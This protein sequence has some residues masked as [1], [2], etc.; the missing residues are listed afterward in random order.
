[1]AS[2]YVLNGNSLLGAVASALSSDELEPQQRVAETLLGLLGTQ[3][4]DANKATAQDA[5]ALQVRYQVEVGFEA[6]HLSSWTQGSR[7]ESYRGFVPDLHPL[8]ARLVSSL[9]SSQRV[10]VF[11]TGLW[12][13]V[14]SR[15]PG[16]SA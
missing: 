6:A 15:R 4:T 5:I 13:V 7:S 16:P 9:P 12:E 2:V 10:E 8:A 11:D 1:M 14:R 3:F